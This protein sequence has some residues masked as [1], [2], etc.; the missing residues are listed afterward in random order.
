MSRCFCSKGEDFLNAW[1]GKWSECP[2]VQCREYN[3]AGRFGAGWRGGR[4]SE[5]PCGYAE[6]LVLCNSQVG[7]ANRQ[8]GMHVALRA[9]LTNRFM[10]QRL[11]DEQNQVPR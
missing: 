1:F 11:G 9:A 8:L 5:F 6:G 7:M 10:L 2:Y 4:D 3:K